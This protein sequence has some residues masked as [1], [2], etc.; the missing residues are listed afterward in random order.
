MKREEYE[1]KP[2]LCTF[3]DDPLPFSKRNNT[4][5][6]SSC[7]ASH[8]NVGVVRNGS[9]CTKKCLHCSKVLTRN[10]HQY[11]DKTCRAEYKYVTEYIPLILEGKKKAHCSNVK[12]YIL[13]LCN[14]KCVKCGIG[15]EWN[16]EPLTLQLDH[17]DGDS[18]NNFPINLRILCPNCHTQTP[19][20]GS[21]GFGNT[22]KKDTDRNRYLREY[23]NA[24]VA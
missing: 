20:H 13:E 14:H 6:N 22:R 15:E 17:I 19:T 10:A 7:A 18:D 2:K 21:K 1:L 12:R 24:P 4:F 9:T 8:N 11:C 5:C 16:G 3:C 23:K